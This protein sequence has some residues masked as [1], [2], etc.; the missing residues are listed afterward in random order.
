MSGTPHYNSGWCIVS[1]FG[2]RNETD[3][4]RNRAEA[5]SLD[6]PLKE[7]SDRLRAQAARDSIHHGGRPRHLLFTGWHPRGV[8]IETTRQGTHAD[9]TAPPA[10]MVEGGRAYRGD[11]HAGRAGDLY[12]GEL[13]AAARVPGSPVP[14]GCPLSQRRTPARG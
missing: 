13:R 14:A 4:I 12:G 2:V 3:W 7:L 11:S 9:S 10:A 6:L 8:R 1:L 5:H